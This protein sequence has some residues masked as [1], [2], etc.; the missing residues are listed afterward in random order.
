M[1]ALSVAGALGALGTGT[2]FAAEAGG[3]PR[4]WEMGLQQPAT[5]VM[6]DLEWFHNG[7]LLPHITGISVFVLL[8]LLYVMLRFNARANPVPSKNSHNTLIEV[9]WTVVPVAILIT[10]A[11]PSFKLLFEETRIPDPDLTV[12]VTGHAWNWEY[13]YPDQG[14]INFTA[15]MTQDSDLKPGEPRLLTASY[16][17]VVPVNKNVHVLVTGADVIHSWAVPAFGV[18]IDAIPG[19][20]NETWFRAEQEGVYYG[21]CS[22]L[23]GKD[24]AFMPIEVHVVSDELFKRWADAAQKDVDEAAKLL[25]EAES[26]SSHKVAAAEG[27]LTS[28]ARAQ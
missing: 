18:K 1:L 24:H 28:P 25:A 26:I 6:H 14:A 11:V 5:P 16:K 8:L 10:I 9:V 2:A 12:K 22:E 20:M 3:P 21:Q 4:D 15:V 7:L 27:A 19:R 13:D 17:V 23:C